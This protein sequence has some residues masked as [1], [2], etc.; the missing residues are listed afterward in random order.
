M[1]GLKAKRT[2]SARS[3]GKAREMLAAGEIDYD[4]FLNLVA[5]SAPSAGHCNT[6]GTAST[7]NSLAEALGMSLPGC[8]AIPRR[9]A[10]GGKS[11]TRRKTHRRNGGEDL[12]T[13]RHPDARSIRKYDRGELRDRRLHQC[14]NPYQRDRTS[15]RRAAHDPR[16]ASS[17]P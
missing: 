14:A 5:S 16:L 8:A 6:M 10:S 17:G 2:G 7:M 13:L 3:R 1:A 4:G 12:K 15:Y 9:I 11:L